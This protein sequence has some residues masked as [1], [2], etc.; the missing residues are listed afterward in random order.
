MPNLDLHPQLPKVKMSKKA[1]FTHFWP[2]FFE[3]VHNASDKNFGGY[4]IP[5]WLVHF[6]QERRQICMDTG[7]ELKTTKTIRGGVNIKF[8]AS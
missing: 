2:L 3:C 6:L 5:Q 7:T 1:I 4:L 8:C